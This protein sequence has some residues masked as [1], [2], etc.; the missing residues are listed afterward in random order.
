VLL[1]GQEVDVDPDRYAQWHSTQVAYPGLNFSSY[2]QMRVDKALEQGRKTLDRNKRIEHYANFQRVLTA[3]VPAIFLYQP[4]YT[5]AVSEKVK[6][7]KIDSLF[8]PQDRFADL[9]DWRVE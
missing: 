5:F 2:E 3:D 7:V 1:F 4:V 8:Y 9:K 6:G